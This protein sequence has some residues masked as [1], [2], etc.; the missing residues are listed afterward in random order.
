MNV[1]LLDLKPQNGALEEELQAAFL[2][3]LRSGYFIM[4]PEVERF[5]RALAEFTGARHVLGVTSGTDAILLAL[6][7]LGIGPGDEVLCPSFTFF[8]TA[9]C[10]ARVGATPVFV[11]SRPEAFNLDLEDA[12]RRIT[13]RTRAIM[14]VHLF[15]Q[16]A[17]MDGVLELARR[18]H[19]RVIEDAAQSLGAR[20]GGRSAGTMGDFGTI[21]F[22]P[23]KNLGALGDAGAL[24]VHDDE[25]AHRSR[26]LRVHG[27]E[28]KYYHPLI[29]GNFRLDALQ[30]AFLS[31]KLPHLPRYAV[32]RRRNARLYFE[33]L[34]PLPAA[35][36]KNPRLVLPVV[37]PEQEHVW[38]QFTL[39]VP[40]ARDELR[41]HLAGRGIGSE[42]YYPVPMHEQACFAYLKHRPE[43]FPVAHQL[44]G[45]VLSLPIYPELEPEQIATVAQAIA[46]FF[47]ARS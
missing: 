15:G 9:G 37:A 8:A 30:A 34:S 22:F 4:G 10:I 32:G 41:A 27:M 16:A 23:S 39:R 7:A 17:G 31:A 24:F 42:I 11:D 25:L 45:E 28:P 29:G 40:G 14:P 43:D 12:A 26:M 44:A 3:V 46:D 1:N 35:A 18:H 33:A 38:N 5:E 19:L 21:S 20:C 36:G 6:M 2:R 13:T 47:A